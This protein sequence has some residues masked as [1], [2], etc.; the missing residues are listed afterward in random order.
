VRPLGISAEEQVV[1]LR[2]LWEGSPGAQRQ[3]RNMV[4]ALTEANGEWVRGK[5]CTARVEPGSLSW[6]VGVVE[7]S[8]GPAFYAFWIEAPGWVLPSR[9]VRVIDDVRAELSGGP[10]VPPAS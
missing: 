1:F 3:T 2:R 4:A 7:R 9:R 5:T 10:T 6:L 8:E